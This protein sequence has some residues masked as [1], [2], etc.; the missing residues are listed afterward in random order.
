MFFPWYERRRAFALD[1]AP[2]LAPA[3]LQTRT[4]DALLAGDAGVALRRAEIGYPLL[5]RLRELAIV[6]RHAAACSDP[7]HT[8]SRALAAAARDFITLPD[9]PACCARDIG[10]FIHRESS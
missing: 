3:L 8:H 4:L 10:A 6:P 1:A 9:D 7:R 2:C 5:V